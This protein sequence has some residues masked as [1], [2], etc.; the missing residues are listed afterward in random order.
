[1][2]SWK[3]ENSVVINAPAEQIYETLRDYNNFGSIFGFG[4][5]PG[6]Y[7]TRIEG[8]EQLVEVGSLVEHRLLGSLATVQFKRRVEELEPDQ[9]LVERYIGPDIEGSGIWELDELPGGTMV[10]FSCDLVDTSWRTKMMYRLAGTIPHRH[11]YRHGLKR[12]KRKLEK[13]A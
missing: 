5:L 6:G 7:R 10:S 1:M 13:D 2:G 12:L 9:R 4:R 8:K 11:V 3:A